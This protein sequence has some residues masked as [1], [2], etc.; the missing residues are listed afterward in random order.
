MALE[1]RETFQP[2]H[3]RAQAESRGGRAQSR[4]SRGSGR[5][6]SPSIAPTLF[7]RM[8]LFSK[9]QKADPKIICD[10]VE[11]TFRRDQDSWEFAYRGLKFCSCAA[12]LSLPSKAELDVIVNTVEALG[13]E[14]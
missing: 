4:S 10:G 11:C 8:G 6:A 5:L 2:G 7:G 14:I 9:A 12:R 1:H 13:P 3:I